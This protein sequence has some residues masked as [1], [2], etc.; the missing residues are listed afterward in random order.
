M[1]FFCLTCDEPIHGSVVSEGYCTRCLMGIAPECDLCH[2]PLEGAIEI[3]ASCQETVDIF[4][5]AEDE[6]GIDLDDEEEFLHGPDFK[7]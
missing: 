5:E 1:S 3:C 2:G 6:L 7:N 4:I